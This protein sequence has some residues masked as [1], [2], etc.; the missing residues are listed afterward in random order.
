MFAATIAVILVNLALLTALQDLLFVLF[1]NTLGLLIDIFQL[2]QI[3]ENGGFESNLVSIQAKLLCPH[4]ED[5]RKSQWGL[6]VSLLN[7]TEN[8]IIREN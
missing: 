4:A 7:A 8:P 6:V 5:I 2:N 3:R 1:K